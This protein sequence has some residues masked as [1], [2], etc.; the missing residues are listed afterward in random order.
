MYAIYTEVR[1]PETAPMAQ[2]I[3][4][5]RT[6]AVPRMQRNGA[7]N[8][9]WMGGPAGRICGVIVFD[10]ERS[11]RANAEQL[12]VGDRPGH[13]P[14]GVAFSSVEVREVLAQL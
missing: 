8:A 12:Q 14:E 3:D 1:V 2:V 4:D 9:Y 13:S 10:D 6:G 7:R 5:L 11:A